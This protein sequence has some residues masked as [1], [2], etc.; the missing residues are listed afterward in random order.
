MSDEGISSFKTTMYELL[1]VPWTCSTSTRGATPKSGRRCEYGE[2]ERGVASAEE[3]SD[4]ARR[5][6][7]NWDI[8]DG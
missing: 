2:V 1:I 6:R 5:T 3:A 7:V 4:A 8:T